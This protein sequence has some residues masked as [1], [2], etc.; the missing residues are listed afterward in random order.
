MVYKVGII[1]A[2]D[3]E[4]EILINNMQ[5][6]DVVESS[7]KDAMEI[8]EVSVPESVTYAHVDVRL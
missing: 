6:K 8:I 7:T 4:V 2:M 3:E 5:D 1:G